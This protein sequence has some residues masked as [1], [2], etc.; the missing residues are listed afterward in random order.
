VKWEQLVYEVGPLHT[1]CPLLHLLQNYTAKFILAT[2]LVIAVVFTKN[3]EKL[4]RME[5]WRNK[6][7][8]KI[9]YAQQ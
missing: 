3:Y 6:N 8:T 1:S 2:L 5:Y 9:T 7:G 4:L